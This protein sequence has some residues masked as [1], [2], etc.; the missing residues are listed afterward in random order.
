MIDYEKIVVAFGLT[1]EVADSIV[2]VVDESV[3]AVGLI[4][5]VAD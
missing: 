2:V 1:S 4:S 5:A 3:E